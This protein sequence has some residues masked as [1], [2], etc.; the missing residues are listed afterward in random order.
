[1]VYW[2]CVFFIIAI[3]F[4]AIAFSAIGF[5]GFVPITIA[6]MAKIFFLFFLALGTIAL[7]LGSKKKTNS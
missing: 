5:V 7:M 6:N 4:S 2:S 3:A 1:M